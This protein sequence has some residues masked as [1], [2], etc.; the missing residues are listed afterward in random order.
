L[1]APVPPP[2]VCVVAAS[3]ALGLMVGPTIAFSASAFVC[4]DFE[5]TVGIWILLAE[6]FVVSGMRVRFQLNCV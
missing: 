5:R 2:G 3:S 6:R 1:V 4:G